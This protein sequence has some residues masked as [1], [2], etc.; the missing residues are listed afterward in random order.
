[1]HHRKKSTISRGNG[2]GGIEPP[3]T[4]LK[5]R[6]S[7]G[8]SDEPTP[9]LT[10]MYSDYNNAKKLYKH[11]LSAKTGISPISFRVHKQIRIFCRCSIFVES[12]TSENRKKISQK[13]R[14]PQDVVVPDR[15]P[16]IWRSRSSWN[17]IFIS[18]PL[19]AFEISSLTLT[20]ASSKL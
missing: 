1:M 20:F 16:F 3:T 19:I 6:R 5:A 9:I 12:G 15:F 7:T 14:V 17:F 10:K 11:F 4:W 13:R 18:M 8:L 2:P